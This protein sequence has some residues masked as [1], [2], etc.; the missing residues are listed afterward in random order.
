MS[1][2]RQTIKQLTRVQH[3]QEGGGKPLADGPL[4][5]AVGLIALEGLLVV[6]VDGGEG[7]VGLGAVEGGVSRALL[8]GGDAFE[9][10]DVSLLLDFL[11]GGGG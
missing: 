7:L 4:D 2:S 10:L 11:H 5:L 9:L 3:G 1:G 8:L 6:D